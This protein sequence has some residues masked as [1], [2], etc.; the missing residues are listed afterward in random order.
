MA[1]Q[2]SF[3]HFIEKSGYVIFFI[4]ITL[5]TAAVLR[6]SI[7]EFVL[8]FFVVDLIG[9]G[10]AEL[11]MSKAYFWLYPDERDIFYGV[12]ESQFMQLN[13]LERRDLLVSLLELPK[14]YSKYMYFSSFAKAIPAF[15]CIFFYWQYE[16]SLWQQFL[17]TMGIASISYMYFSGLGYYDS[18]AKIGAWI[19]EL[20]EKFDLSEE[21]AALQLPTHSGYG[22]KQ[23][24]LMQ[25]FIIL[26]SL[27]VQLMVLLE[28]DKQSQTELV[29]KLSL[30]GVIGIGLSSR[31]WYL[32][33]REMVGG[34]TSIFEEMGKLN[35]SQN[36]KAI[37][38]PASPLLASF[39]QTFNSLT[40]RIAASEA[41]LRQMVFHE[42]EKSR[43][44]AL[45]EISG[46]VAHD[47]SAPLHVTQYCLEELRQ[48]HVTE[49]NQKYF[50]QMHLNVSQA[51]NLV[52]SLRA[53]LKNTPGDGN[54]SAFEET[55]QHVWRLLET[56]FGVH[57]LGRIAV[58]LDPAVAKLNFAIPR[59]D[60]M[61]ILDNLYR[62]SIMNLLEHKVA[63]PKL[64]LRLDHSTADAA[65]I[66]M[67]DNGSGLTQEQFDQFTDEHNYSHS[68]PGRSLGLRLTRRLIEQHGGELALLPR[69]IPSAAGSP[70]TELASASPGTNFRLT[71]K[72]LPASEISPLL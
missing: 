30:L 15:L 62:N 33:R 4:A 56:Q 47:L 5:L 65:S 32:S 41:E 50:E 61:Q 67:T 70:A 7:F 25:A 46:L 48:K 20:H 68:G 45:G 28:Y 26:F 23:D 63:N 51:I 11:L 9:L 37:A 29:I 71:L 8:C 31:I 34:L 19:R 36:Y 60:L 44:E 3:I 42:A 43:Y 35:Y 24:I 39:G 10:L 6:P 53:R 13:K 40:K 38:L 59:I 14:H 12:N 17:L 66:I 54:I 64:S 2:K 52:T 55:H 72:V 18:R 49:D 27:I 58:D 69:S 57:A 1:N 16:R 22:E 21:F